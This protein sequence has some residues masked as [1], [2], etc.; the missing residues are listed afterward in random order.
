MTDNRVI[1]GM[2]SVLVLTIH[3]TPRGTDAA[4][5][6]HDGTR[7]S[8]TGA[9]KGQARPCILVLTGRGLLVTPRSLKLGG[10]L[11]FCGITSLVFVPW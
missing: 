7:P 10:S 4:S 1:V 8:L 2:V 5:S 11:L 6:C 9:L 3:G